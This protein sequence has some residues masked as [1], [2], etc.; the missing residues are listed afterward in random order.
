M[1]WADL[2]RRDF[3]GLA[4]LGLAATALPS[5]ARAGDPPPVRDPRATDGDAVHEPDWDERLTITV[6]PDSADLVEGFSTEL[7]DLRRNG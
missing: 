3:L 1:L 6:G 2:G 7:A 4:A 5:R